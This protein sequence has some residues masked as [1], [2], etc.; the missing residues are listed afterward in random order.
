LLRS[1]V[2]IR[3]CREPASGRC[4]DAAEALVSGLR[5]SAGS[6]AAKA[7]LPGGRCWSGI[8]GT[9]Y[10]QTVAAET[11]HPLRALLRK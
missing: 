9:K 5:E 8:S 11:E 2:A 1:A 3:P 7:D 10:V 4:S 6:V